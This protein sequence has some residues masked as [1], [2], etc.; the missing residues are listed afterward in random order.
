MKKEINQ[1][2]IESWGIFKFLTRETLT[3]IKKQ[4]NKEIK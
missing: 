4:R 3:E 2:K 1:R